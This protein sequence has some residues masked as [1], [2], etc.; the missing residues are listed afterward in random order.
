LDVFSE[1]FVGEGEAFVESLLGG[2]DNCDGDLSFLGGNEGNS[3]TL[4]IVRC[5]V[6]ACGLLAYHL[7]CANHTELLH[8]ERH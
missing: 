6:G 4:G 1:Q 8:F 5:V 3:Q 7:A 2:V